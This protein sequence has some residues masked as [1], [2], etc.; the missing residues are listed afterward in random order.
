MMS[1]FWLWLVIG[2]RS[3]WKRSLTTTMNERRGEEREREMSTGVTIGTCERGAGRIRQKRSD[4]IY[5]FLYSAAFSTAPLERKFF[6]LS[7]LKKKKLLKRDARRR[8]EDAESKCLLGWWR[9][10]KKR[11][12]AFLYFSRIFHLLYSLRPFKFIPTSSPQRPHTRVLFIIIII[13]SYLIRVRLFFCQSELT[14]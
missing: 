8:V 2:R 7:S 5:F 9:A 12:C 3:K 4:S 6:L 11:H 13:I 14:K 1:V 10:V